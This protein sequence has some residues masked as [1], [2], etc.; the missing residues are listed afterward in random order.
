MTAFDVADGGS[1]SAS[2]A[3]YELQSS[4]V[5]GLAVGVV[6]AQRKI[7]AAEAYARLRSASQNSRRRL[8]DIADDVAL[9]GAVAHIA[10]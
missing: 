9:T 4:R 8:L 5:I 6:T 7:S 1:P 2:N 3:I 10:A